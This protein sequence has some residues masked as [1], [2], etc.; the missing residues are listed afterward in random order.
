MAEYFAERTC[1]VCGA[2]VAVKKR[3]FFKTYYDYMR[4]RFIGRNKKAILCHSC[5]ADMVLE[6]RKKLEEK[7]HADDHD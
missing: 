5:Y 7:N 1:D 2:R 6:L 3:L 4:I